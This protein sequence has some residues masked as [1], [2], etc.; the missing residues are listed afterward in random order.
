MTSV[1]ECLTFNEN[2]LFCIVYMSLV[3]AILAPLAIYGA[4]DKDIGGI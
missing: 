3:N 1:I 4:N 2:Y